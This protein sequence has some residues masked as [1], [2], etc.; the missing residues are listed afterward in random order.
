MI[1]SKMIA[2][3]V[4]SLTGGTLAVIAIFIAEALYPGYNIY[5]NYV[6]DLGV[7]PSSLIFNSAI[8][9]GG[10]FGLVNA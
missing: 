6:S 2:S 4:L 8:L 5:Q 10:I 7:G 1:D 3:G 9:V